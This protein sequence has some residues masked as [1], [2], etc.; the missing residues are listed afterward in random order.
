MKSRKDETETKKAPRGI[1]LYAGAFA[2][3]AATIAAG[4]ALGYGIAK[5]GQNDSNR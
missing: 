3:A 1:R 5:F 2:K 4:V